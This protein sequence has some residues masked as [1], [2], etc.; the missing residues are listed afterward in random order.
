MT[1]TDADTQRHAERY[2]EMASSVRD[3]IPVIGS[4]EVREA[5]RLIALEYDRLAGGIEAVCKSLGT[6]A[7]SGLKPDPE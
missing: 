1:D 3:L 7:N 4:P 5:L 6:T 2:R